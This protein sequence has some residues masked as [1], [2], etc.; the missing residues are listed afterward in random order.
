EQALADLDPLTI[1]DEPVS[2]P[3]AEEAPAEAEPEE[4][5]AEATLEE[6]PAEAAPETPA[7][8]II[9]A[10]D[11]VPE[12]TAE[13]A[14]STP[15]PADI[16]SQPFTEEEWNLLRETVASAE[17]PLSF[18]QIHDRLR[19]ARNTAGVLRTNEE[20]RTLIKQAINNGVLERQGKGNRV[21]YRIAAPPEAD[22]TELL[23]PPVDTGE[24]EEI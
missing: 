15:Q 14:A 10:P 9:E 22:L 8:E 20:L 2:E 16:I 11:S 13:V 18:A 19:A 5:P 23:A 7:A 17:R 6:T 1:L 21:T 4:T 12:S 24:P 3:E